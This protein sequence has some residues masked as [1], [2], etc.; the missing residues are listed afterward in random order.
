MTA[1]FAAALAAGVVVGCG[2]QAPPE[3]RSSE[4]DAYLE[5]IYLDVDDETR[6]AEHDATQEYVAACMA[7]QGFEYHPTKAP[8]EY[9]IPEFSAESAADVGYGDVTEANGPDVPPIRFSAMPGDDPAVD[10]N[11]SYAY[12]LAP[13]AQEQYWRAGGDR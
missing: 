2:A 8:P 13:E 4:L 1:A 7:E 10:F 5:E 9:A 12:G 6:I 3:E 11:N